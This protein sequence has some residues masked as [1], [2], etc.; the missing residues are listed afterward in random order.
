MIVASSASEC[1][2][3]KGLADF[4]DLMVHHIGSQLT[5]DVVLQSPR[6]DGKEPRRNDLLAVLLF[7]GI[8][9]QIA[10]DLLAD[11]AIQRL[12]LV[13]CFDHIIAVTPGISDQDIPLDVR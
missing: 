7:V 11:K 2:A 12:I 13:E 5:F 6:S 8:I 10:C 1:L 4:I 3:Q 9:E